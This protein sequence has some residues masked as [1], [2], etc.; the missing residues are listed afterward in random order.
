[1]QFDERLNELF[2]ISIEKIKKN[3]TGAFKLFKSIIS[4]KNR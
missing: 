4:I 1:M 2:I 3:K